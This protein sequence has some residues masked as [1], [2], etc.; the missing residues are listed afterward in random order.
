[1]RV[2]LAACVTVLIAVSFA[3]DVFDIHEEA[4]ICNGNGCYPRVFVPTD[5]FQVVKEGQEIPKGSLD[6]RPILTQGL[7][8]RINM[9]APLIPFV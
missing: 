6:E 4:S 5:E 7:H 8:V 3:L 1:M 2:F 9:Q